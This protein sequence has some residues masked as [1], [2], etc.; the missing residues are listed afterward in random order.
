MIMNKIGHR[1][2]PLS[3]QAKELRPT[4]YT[5]AICIEYHCVFYSLRI[6]CNYKV[7][8]GVAQRLC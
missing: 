3:L 6:L 5:V 2:I 4:C 8:V 7:T 1:H